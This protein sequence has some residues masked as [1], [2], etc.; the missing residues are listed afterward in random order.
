MATND[1]ILNSRIIC[2][3]EPVQNTEHARVTVVGYK[4]IEGEYVVLDKNKAKEIFYPEGKAFA[5]MFKFDRDGYNI[6]PNSFIEF[7][8]R[9]SL[10]DASFK[11]DEYIV[12]YNGKVIQK[13]LISIINLNYQTSLEHG[14]ITQ[15]ELASCI[16]KTEL[17]NYSNQFL[18][19]SGD[20]LYGLFKY[21]GVSDI[22]RPI[23]GKETNK[24]EVDKTIYNNYCIKVNQKE[25][26]LGNANEMP[27]KQVGIIDCMDDKQLAEWFKDQLKTC[28]QAESFLNIKKEVFQDFTSRFK[29]TNDVIDKVRLDRIK[30]KIASLEFTFKEINELIAANSS[31]TGILNDTLK[32]MKDEY[33][34][35]WVSDI[36]SSKA[37]LEKEIEILKKDKE[38][39]SAELQKIDSEYQDKKTSLETS[40]NQ[41]RKELESAL[42]EKESELKAIEEHHDLIVAGIKSNL[43]SCQ[44]NKPTTLPLEPIIFEAGGDS[45]TKLEENEGYSFSSLLE[46]NIE[47]EKI[48]ETLKVQLKKNSDLFMNQACFIPSVSWAYLFAKA[49]R[50]SKLYIMHVEHDW[51]HYRDFLNNGLETVLES[52][53]QNE[54]INHVLVLDSLNLTQPECGL[55]PLMD[56]VSGYSLIIQGTGKSFPNNFKIF[57]TILPYSDENKIGLPLDNSTFAEWARISTNEDRIKLDVA[58]LSVSTQTGYFEPKDIAVTKIQ[59]NSSKV[60][61]GY[62]DK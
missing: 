29:E 2:F 15:D 30:G 24:Y 20:Y 49:I 42:A 43:I 3:I 37:V 59:N 46:K 17:K 48:P 35:G 52:C 10:K 53:Y 22:I 9:T 26:Y 4:N 60:G 57:A 11:G 40:H 23:K 27:F 34:I 31:L 50:N 12:D 25:Y 6:L 62:F 38:K 7:S 18:F 8:A 54:T 58:F 13:N 51:L 61:N 56:V 32:N 16:D 36:E 1:E 45:F 47:L 19:R 44:V 33:Y 39:K 28:A 55:K 41:K 5:P 21:D 14:F